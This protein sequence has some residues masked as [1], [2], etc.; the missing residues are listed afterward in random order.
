LGKV[1]RIEFEVFVKTENVGWGSVLMLTTAEGDNPYGNAG[2]RQPAIITYP[3]DRNDIDS[4]LYVYLWTCLNNDCD[5]HQT[6]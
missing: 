6:G 2:D 3:S 1:F 5:Y 4:T